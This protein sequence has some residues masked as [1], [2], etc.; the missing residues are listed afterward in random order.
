MFLLA[1][2]RSDGWTACPE[3]VDDFIGIRTRLKVALLVIQ[4]IAIAAVILG[5]YLDHADQREWIASV[6][7][8]RFAP[9]VGLCSLMYESSG[10][11]VSST[12]PG[13]SEISSILSEQLA[14]QLPN[15]GN[16]QITSIKVV[17]M[18]AMAI[19]LDSARSGPRIAL[20]I[21]LQDGRVLSEVEV[22]RA[23]L[24]SEIEGRFLKEPLFRWG[25][26]LQWLGILITFFALA[27]EKV[28]E[29]I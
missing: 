15:A 29:L 3:L 1:S 27:V 22:P 14:G 13:F 7:A 4:G 19:N 28:F 23:W 10:L 26:K 20:S 5:W 25:E 24:Q 9:A 17:G 8:P 12:T 2:L 6:F 21:A 18:T 16:F 11:E